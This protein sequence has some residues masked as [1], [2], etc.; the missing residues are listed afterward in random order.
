[1]K[2]IDKLLE[3]MASLRNPETGCPWDVAQ[4]FATIAPYTIEE[5]YEVADAIRKQDYPALCD[6]LGDLLLQVVFHARMAEEAE[7]FDF[8]DVVA[9]INAKLLRRH[10]HVFGQQEERS[11]ADEQQLAWE[12]D[13]ARE[14]E[15]QGLLEDIPLAM[16]AIKRAQKLQKRAAAVGFDW[17]E[18]A[19]AQ[20]K[21]A[22]E[23]SELEAE[24]AA[25][26]AGSDRQFSELGDLL[27]A[28]TNL[29]RKLGFD[30]EAALRGANAKFE[31][32]FA[33]IEKALR[34]SGDSLESAS[35]AQMDALWDEAKGHP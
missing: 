12:R 21:V 4:S 16:P 17:P 10:P 30:T 6:E 13:K 8:G 1:M 34:A 25:G 9:A 27:F 23:L 29:G 26:P 22:E 15:G 3:V 11:S 35:L 5:A 28:L 7:L 33:H 18:V 24:L 14:R 19:G 20:A 2:E 31:R 32:R